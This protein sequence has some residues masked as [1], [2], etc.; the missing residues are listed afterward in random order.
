[1]HHKVFT[2]FVHQFVHQF[3]T[4][5]TRH[6]L[7]TSLSFHASKSVDCARRL[8]FAAKTLIISGNKSR[9]LVIFAK[10]LSR[11]VIISDVLLTA[12]GDEPTS[13]H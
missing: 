5:C 10:P 11:Q 7:C 6:G 12:F 3:S 2:P 9:P 13:Q 8:D 4:L 1:M